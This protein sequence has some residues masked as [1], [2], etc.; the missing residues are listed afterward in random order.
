MPYHGTNEEA[1]KKILRLG[2]RA[3]RDKRQGFDGPAQFWMTNN[4][5]EAMRHAKL[6]GASPS[7]PGTWEDDYRQT[8]FSRPTVLYI[9]DEGLESVP[10]HRRKAFRN[11]DYITH[12]HPHRIDP[13]H[14]SI[15]SQGPEPNISTP[16]DWGE[17]YGTDLSPEKK[18]EGIEADKKRLEEIQNYKQ[19]VWNW[20][21]YQNE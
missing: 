17:N 14:I 20:G 21:R 11:V 19:D 6:K 15:Y 10:Y 18:K 4:L 13:K 9:S 7:N 12:R 8:G 1:A 5:N 2:T 3:F 16:F